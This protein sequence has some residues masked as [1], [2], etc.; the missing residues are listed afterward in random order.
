MLEFAYTSPDD[1]QVVSQL[2]FDRFADAYRWVT[3]DD[4]IA[5]MDVQE[6]PMV[7][8][9]LTVSNS[10]TNTQFETFGFTIKER[11]TLSGMSSEGFG[12]EVENSMDG[13]E[14]WFVSNKMA[15][16]RP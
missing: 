14:S 13:G 1:R 15:F 16:T 4:T 5:Y 7:D 11:T 8:G 12:I 6:G 2:S 9:K 10:E 3:I